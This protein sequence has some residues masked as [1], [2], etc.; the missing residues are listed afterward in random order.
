MKHSTERMLTTHTGSLSRPPG[1]ISAMG[2]KER[3][4]DYDADEYAALVR[5]AVTSVVSRQLDAGV[6]VI[7][8]GEQG[9]PSY[10]TYVKDR[11]GRFRQNSGHA[12]NLG[13]VEAPLEPMIMQTARPLVSPSR[14]ENLSSI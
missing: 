14:P 10:L 2:L 6:A 13:R 7:C 4:E 11:L 3:G 5:D 1:L 9:K 12:L 8:D